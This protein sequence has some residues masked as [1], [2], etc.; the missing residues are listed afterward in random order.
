MYSNYDHKGVVY[1]KRQKI[2]RGQEFRDRVRCEALENMS[3]KHGFNV[4]SLDNKHSIDL[5]QEGNIID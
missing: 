5:A 2:S 1:S 4:Y 3:G